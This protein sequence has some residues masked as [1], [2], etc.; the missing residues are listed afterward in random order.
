MSADY[1]R[2]IILETDFDRTVREALDAFRA[3]GMVS[4]ARTDLREQFRYTLGHDWHNL[5][6]Y[7]LM[8]V[9]S[10]DLAL[11]T[12]ERNPDSEAILPATF[13]IDELTDGRTAVTASEPLS[14]LLWDS[15]SRRQAPELAAFAE[16][17]DDKVAR[18][19]AR[20]ERVAEKRPV[21]TVASVL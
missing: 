5:R 3:E 9:W 15:A 10:P 19:V 21:P 18:V 17:Q 16:A 12:Y 6:R 13:L 11:H 4:I 7:L 14:W 8:L 20:L 2:R 1:K